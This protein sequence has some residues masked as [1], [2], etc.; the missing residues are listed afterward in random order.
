M[1]LKDTHCRWLFA[2]CM[3][4]GSISY[5]VSKNGRNKKGMKA[6]ARKFD[7]Q[8]NLDPVKR[9]KEFDIFALQIKKTLA[10]CALEHIRGKDDP[11]RGW[12][13]MEAQFEKKKNR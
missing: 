10:L 11:E 12:E 6:W 13:A 4:G 5:S 9:P 3:S 7:F 8:N 1:T 2:D